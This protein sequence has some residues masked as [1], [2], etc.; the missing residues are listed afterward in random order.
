MGEEIDSLP[1]M[2]QQFIFPDRRADN[3][4]GIFKGRP[5]L[6]AAAAVKAKRS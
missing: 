3:R 6:S 1:P 4:L 2:G 5:F